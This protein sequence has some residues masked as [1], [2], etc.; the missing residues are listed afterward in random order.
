M[1]WNLLPGWLWNTRSTLRAVVIIATNCASIIALRMLRRRWCY[2]NHNPS[3]SPN[4]VVIIT[5]CDSGLGY[6]MAQLCLKTGMTVMGTFIS[7]ES[8]GY[9]NLVKE[10]SVPGSLISFIM[11]LRNQQNIEL[12][13]KQIRDWFSIN[14]ADR[15]YAIVN[16]AGVM[17]FGEAEWLTSN[18]IKAQLDVNIAGTMLFTI[19][20]LD[21]VREYRSR[22]VV[23]TS[24]CGRQALPGLSIYSATKSALRAWTDAI[25]MELACHG[26]PVIEFLPGSFL[27]Q[28]NICSRQMPNF[29]EM[30]SNLSTNQQ[31]FYDD[32]FHRY[33]GYLAPLCGERAP[34]KFRENDPLAKTIRHVLFDKNPKPCYSYEP[35]RYTFYY[36]AFKFL[37]LTLRDRLVRQFLAMP[38]F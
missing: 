25:R 19:P 29:E 5:G 10:A 9:K 28:S 7:T 22:L 13:H 18:I 12:I 26:V 21:L 33:T 27:F 32:Y 30:W 36:N 4:E 20:L 8:E 6:N 15:L 2:E 31:S 24:H 3:F 11:D 35:W 16:N 38:M 34:E 17:C 1:G 14:R 23:V 37:P